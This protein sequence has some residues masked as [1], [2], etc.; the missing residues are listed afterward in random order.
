MFPNLM[1]VAD[2]FGFFNADP[3]VLL[4][5]CFPMRTDRISQADIEMAG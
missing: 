5:N 2:D 3:R 4:A 1:L